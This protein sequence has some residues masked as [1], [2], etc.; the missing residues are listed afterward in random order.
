MREESEAH[1]GNE[2]TGADAVV[3]AHP[4]MDVGI[5][6]FP[7][8]VLVAGVVGLFV[9]HEAAA[10][11]P[12]GVAVADEA[13]QVRTVIAALQM[14]PREVFVLIEDNLDVEIVMVLFIN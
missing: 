12:D 14:V 10:L 9:D 4:L 8:V 2:A 5:V 7:Q 6:S 11:H 3:D 13:H 1:R